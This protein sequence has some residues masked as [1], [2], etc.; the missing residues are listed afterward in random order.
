MTFYKVT[1]IIN[2]YRILLILYINNIRIVGFIDLGSDLTLIRESDAK[3]I[4]KQWDSNDIRPMVDFGGTIVHSL[5]SSVANNS[6]RGVNAK[7]YMLYS[8][9]FC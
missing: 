6:I 5:G 9:G 1:K 4:F 2:M 8:I 7:M 3:E